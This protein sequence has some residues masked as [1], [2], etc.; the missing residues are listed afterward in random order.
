MTTDADPLLM[1]GLVM[2]RATVNEAGIIA[3]HRVEMFRDMGQVPTEELAV[4][5]LEESTSA[6]AQGLRDGSYVGWLVRDAGQVVAGAG[7][8]I[9]PH[10]PRVTHDGARVAA[11]SVPLVVNV[12]TEPQWR[13]RGIAR[14]LMNTLMAWSAA[15]GF[16]RV[17]LHASD[18][19]RLLYTSL[20]FVA[21]NEM[22]WWP[23][24]VPVRCRAA[25]RPPQRPCSSATTVARA[26]EECT[27]KASTSPGRA[28]S[29]A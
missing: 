21:S 22:R 11:S 13:R 19:G 12:Y 17:V 10:L 9:K 8:H 25:R 15:E 23:P 14:A 26:S 24:A 6:L 7:V 2:A 18:S 27:G 4:A 29:S 1:L 16:D 28:Q 20:G 5:L 3:R